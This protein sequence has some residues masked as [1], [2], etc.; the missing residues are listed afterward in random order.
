[1]CER[2]YFTKADRTPGRSKAFKTTATAINLLYPRRWS[3][4]L[5]C[6]WVIQTTIDPADLFGHAFSAG[7]GTWAD[8]PHE[9]G[10]HWTG[11]E[12]RYATD[13]GTSV[14]GNSIEAGVGAIWGEDPRYFPAEP[15]TSLKSRI[16]RAAKWTVL[17]R[18]ANGD[19]GL[20]YA[21]LIAIPASNAITAAWRPDSET[22]GGHLLIRTATGFGAQL[23]GN[24]WHE[25][26]PGVKKKLFH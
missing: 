25:L 4:L 3:S 20:A 23:V 13:V 10:T 17:A 9:L 12:K 7:F 19:I 26:W 5:S 24:E 14:P 6:S 8:S 18:N 11:F 22:G 16:L 2:R 15:G 1:M 21:R